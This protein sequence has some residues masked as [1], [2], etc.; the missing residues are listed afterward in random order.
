MEKSSDRLQLMQKKET[1]KICTICG[2]ALD[3]LPTIACTAC[4]TMY[5]SDCWAYNQ[6]C[7]VYGCK[8]QSKALAKRCESSPAVLPQLQ[9]QLV[10]LK[11]MSAVSAE[12]KSIAE[13]ASK[14]RWP[15]V[16]KITQNNDSHFNELDLKEFCRQTA[17]LYIPLWI[18]IPVFFII[19]MG[20]AIDFI[21]TLCICTEPDLSMSLSWLL[22]NLC[23]IPLGILFSKRLSS[24]SKANM[25]NAAQ[26]A[27]RS[28]FV[29]SV[30][31]DPS[32]IQS[33]LE[34][35][36]KELRDFSQKLRITFERSK[37]EPRTD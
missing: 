11:E 32:L 3:K 12:V 9:Q 24:E 21:W 29:D 27:E 6:G 4:G 30:M 23:L 20:G 28:K 19:F 22:L 2:D 31:K 35:H 13:T 33:E 5:H 25:F 36:Y 10:F 14:K 18:A 16:R 15:L 26:T 8:Q 37:S 7:A 1:D 34:S 17:L